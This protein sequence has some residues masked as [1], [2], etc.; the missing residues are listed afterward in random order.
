MALQFL[1]ISN[2]T[3]SLLYKPTLGAVQWSKLT[4]I[5]AHATNRVVNLT[6]SVPGDV[7]RYYRL[8][9]PAQ[10]QGFSGILRVDGINLAAGMV[11][12]SFSA[13]SNRSYSVQYQSSPG[14]NAWQRLKDVPAQAS[15]QLVSVTDNRKVRPGAFIAWLAPRSYDHN[16]PNYTESQ[17]ASL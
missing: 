13:V 16:W 14:E 10:A 8:V 4:D 15:D 9:T 1:A 12:L 11:T 3:Y 6:N 17:P 2:R 7:Q 5:P